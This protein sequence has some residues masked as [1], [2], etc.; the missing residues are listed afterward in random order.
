MHGLIQD[1][2][3][4]E[5]HNHKIGESVLNRLDDVIEAISES[6]QYKSGLNLIPNL[7]HIADIGRDDMDDDVFPSAYTLACWATFIQTCGNYPAAEAIKRQIVARAKNTDQKELAARL[8]DLAL[9]LKV[10]GKY[11]EAE[12]L[13]HQVLGIDRQTIGDDHPN[14]A[15]RLNNLAGMLVTQGKHTTAEQLFRQALDI[16]Q[17]AL[18]SEYPHIEVVRERLAACHIAQGKP[19]E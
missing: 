7:I 19:P 12:K 9:V 16:F 11:N 18:P 3:R 8:N 4:Q 1:A 14:Y 6:G 10:Q 15:R 5:D 13:Y 17:H 2:S